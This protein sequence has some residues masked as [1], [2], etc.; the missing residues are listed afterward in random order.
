M[1]TFEEY[2]LLAVAM[3]QYI[4]NI[5]SNDTDQGWAMQ[6]KIGYWVPIDKLA[7]F[8]FLRCINF[9]IG[10]IQDFWNFSEADPWNKVE[11]NPARHQYMVRDDEFIF[12]PLRESYTIFRS[13]S[14]K[15]CAV[16]TFDTP[17]SIQKVCQKT[18]SL[19]QYIL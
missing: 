1:R 7:S 2:A 18:G 13:V 9:T 16:K 10:E 14:S 15:S 17:S 11:K 12:G 19:L 5:D 3:A 4:R 8:D 6:G